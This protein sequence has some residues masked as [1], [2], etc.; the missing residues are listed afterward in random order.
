MYV[1][2]AHDLRSAEYSMVTIYGQSFITFNFVLRRAQRIRS[3]LVATNL[4]AVKRFCC[5]T[6]P[7]FTS[8]RNTTI[9]CSM[10]FVIR[11]S[12]V[13]LLSFIFLSSEKRL[14]IEEISD[15]FFLEVNFLSDSLVNFKRKRKI[16]EYIKW[17]RQDADAYR[18]T[19]RSCSN[20]GFRK[21]DIEH[22]VVTVFC[23]HKRRYNASRTRDLKI[24][25]LAFLVRS[26]CEID[27]AKQCIQDEESLSGERTTWSIKERGRV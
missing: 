5:F 2:L 20:L 17:T 26:K 21:I 24:R 4:V 6:S 27:N 8:S 19:S 7:N 12:S 18:A 9:I 10:S 22:S 1:N 3:N 13:R 14:K 15:L 16:H 23:W 25:S 11:S